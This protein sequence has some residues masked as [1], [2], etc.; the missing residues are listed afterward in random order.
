MPAVVSR[1]AVMPVGG[2][3]ALD[4]PADDASHA[5]MYQERRLDQ[6]RAWWETNGWSRALSKMSSLLT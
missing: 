5:D 6:C 3:R 1:L 2:I 4:L